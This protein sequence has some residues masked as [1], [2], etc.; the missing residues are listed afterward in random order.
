MAEFTSSC[1]LQ[2]YLDKRKLKFR[3]MLFD[4]CKEMNKEDLECLCFVY[5]LKEITESNKATDIF[6]ALVDEKKIEDDKESLEML[7]FVL[8]QSCLKKDLED[9]VDRYINTSTSKEFKDGGVPATDHHMSFRLVDT[10][11]NNKLDG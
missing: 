5:D 10:I 1:Q 6:N 7:K 4:I 9:I 8:T 2:R 3:A 11:I